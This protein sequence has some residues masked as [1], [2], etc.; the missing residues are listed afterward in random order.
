MSILH[1]PLKENEYDIVIERGS[2]S[3]IGLAAKAVLKRGAKAL[4]ITD[5]NV[6]P[7]YEGTV[8]DSLK[9]EGIDSLTLELEPGEGSKS[10]KTLE[11]IYSFAFGN[12]FTRGD[13]IIALGGGIVGD[14]AGF[15]AATIF[16]G[17]D[18]IQVPT[19][20][21]AQVDSSVGGKVAIN[22]EF[23]KNLIGAFYQP[24]HV[25]IDPNTL[26]TLT[27]YY[28]MDGMAEVIKYGCIK[29]S[30]LFDILDQK[31]DEIDE[32][33]EDMIEQCLAI[34]T[35]VVLKD[36]RDTGERMVLNFGHTIGHALEK[37]Y[38]NKGLSHGR[39]VFIGMCI[40]AKYGENHNITEKGTADR[41]I[42][43]GKKYGLEES[44]EIDETEQVG[45]AISIDKK[46]DGQEINI[47][48]LEKIGKANTMRVNKKQF[49][50]DIQKLLK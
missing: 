14:I 28:F 43:C 18:L 24:K 22:T 17:V 2:L 13:A 41:I 12:G 47:V 29:S 19:S 38:A 40:M 11:K 3:K 46:A 15:A 1:V 50:D 33:L 32:L 35:E 7:L 44:F 48:L 5:T 49:A 23:G 45:D 6:G 36:E 16:R 31:H 4:I 26:K 37:T 9:A 39:G 20:L 8:K 21:L 42:E 34:K 25:L 30:I 10:L 27:P